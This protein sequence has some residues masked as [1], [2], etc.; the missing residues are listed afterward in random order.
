[1]R[2]PIIEDIAQK[3]AQGYD[4][5]ELPEDREKA[6]R[7]F[8]EQIGQRR[9]ELNSFEV[10]LRTGDII[11][12]DMTS[13]LNQTPTIDP[14]SREQAIA[15][16][17]D[18][19]KGVPWYRR[20]LA[21][22]AA[23]A[24]WWQENVSQ[25]SAAIAIA[26]AA[27]V[28]PGQNSFDTRLEKA[29]QRITAGKSIE[30]KSNRI[31]D[32]IEAAT[33]A[34][35][36]TDA[37]WGLKGAL[38][39]LVDPLNLVGLG[40]PGKAM[41]ALPLLRPLLFP[42]HVIDRTPDVVVRKIIGGGTTVAKQI[43]GL[44]QLT[45]PHFTTQVK[46]VERRVRA[47]VDGRFGPALLAD[48]V[49]KDTAE[50]LGNLSL[51]PEDGSPYSLR[52]VFNHIEQTFADSPNGLEKW[53][54]F[55]DDLQALTPADASASLS[56]FVS[57]LELKAITKG[58][59][60]LSGEVIEGTIRQR[61]AKTIG[62]LLE[63]LAIDETVAQGVAEAI[64]DKIF[65]L[66]D[67]IW[68]KKVEP[69]IIRPWAVS[70]LA[71]TGF[72]PMNMV[73]DI[74]VSTLGM[75][76]LGKRGWN[77]AEFKWLTAGLN[78][79]P[80]DLFNAE[81]QQRIL[82]D[83]GPNLYNNAV[84][85]P[86]VIK[87]IFKKAVLWPVTL[88][89][90]AGWAIRRSA[91]TNRYFKEFDG[92][93]RE[94]GADI[95]PEINAMRDFMQTEV[96]QGLE[97]LRDEISMKV[98]AAVS[99]GNP[100]VIR[101]LKKTMTS[102]TILRKSQMD[103][104]LKNP[105]VPTDVRRAFTDVLK[106]DVITA[107]NV[108]EV[109]A[110]VRTRL[111]DYH[112]FSAASIRD[113]FQDILRSIPQRPPRS[114]AEA[115]GMLRMFQQAFDDLTQLPR[116]INAHARLRAKGLSPTERSKILDEGFE[117]IDV[118]IGGARKELE[119]ILVK[120][121]PDI[122]RLIVEN[123]GT[124]LKKGAAI[125]AIDDIFGGYRGISEN[126]R[127]TW[128][129][130]RTQKE[131]LFAGT[132]REERG[133][134]FWNELE[135]IGIESWSAEYSSRAQA[136]TRIRD[137]WNQIFDMLPRDLTPKDRE[138]VRRGLD[139]SINAVD[140]DINKIR[141]SID[142]ATAALDANPTGPLADQKRQRIST[143]SDS[144]AV[145]KRQLNELVT[146]MEK[147]TKVRPR[148]ATPQA[149]RD[150]DRNLKLMQA[151]IPEAQS[152]DLFQH[153]SE[154]LDDIAE[155][156]A[157]RDEVFQSFIPAILKPEWESLKA[158]RLNLVRLAAEEPTTLGQQSIKRQQTQLTT[159]IK[160]FRDRIERGEAAQEV[161]N[162]TGI[163]R[164]SMTQ[165]AER[166]I[167]EGGAPT[168]IEEMIERVEALADA[169]DEAALSF[170]NNLEKGTTTFAE[171]DI[172]AAIETQPVIHPK[173]PLTKA[174]SETILERTLA[175]GGSITSLTGQD[176]K[177]LA[178]EGK[179]GRYLVGAFPDLEVRIPLSEASSDLIRQFTQEHVELL[180]KRNH[181][182]G[183]F[184]DEEA[185]VLDVSVSVEERNSAMRLSKLKNQDSIFDAVSGEVLPT[186]EIA[187]PFVA[188]RQQVY[189]E[190]Y[191]RVVQISEAPIL[192]PDKLDILLQA[193]T[194]DLLPTPILNEL[195]EE[196]LIEPITRLKNGKRRVK[197]TESGEDALQTRSPD[198]D[199]DGLTADMPPVVRELDTVVET[200][201]ATVE[202]M[203]DDMVRLWDNPPLRT[204]QESALG[205]S[206]DR[207]ADYMD[208]RP[209]LNDAIQVARQVGMK[210][211][212]TNYNRWFV[213][214][215]NRSTL[216][217][218][219]QRF[220]P[221]W[222]YES[223]RWP[224]LASL[225]AKRPVLAKSIMLSGGDWDYG[226]TP[227]PGGFEFNPMKGTAAGATR[228]TLARDFP[229][230]QSG[231]RGTIEQGFDW[232]ARGGVY[233]N[234]LVTSAVN[235]LQGEPAAIPPPPV[236]LI[237]HGMAAAGV[238]LPSG[239]RE[240]A[241]DSRYSQFLIDQVIADK[242]GANPVETR[243]LA[244]NGDEKAI[245]RLYLAEKEAALRM[246]AINQSSVLRYRPESKRD[247]IES[248]NEAIERIAGIPQDVMRDAQKL[249]I[250]YYEITA[251]SGPQHRAIREAS[252]NFDAFIGASIALRPLE[253]QRILRK[254]TAFWQ[255]IET[256]REEN[257][258]ARQTLS[259]R[260]KQG[261]VSGP[262]FLDERSALARERGAIFKAV[263]ALP[264]FIEV[265]IGLEA[266]LAHIKKYG[267]PSPLVSPI[268]EALEQYYSISAE[269]SMDPRT[270]DIDWGEYF[271]KREDVLNQ[272][273]EPIRSIMQSE[274]RRAETESERLLEV[275][276]PLM[277]EYF[278]IRSGVMDEIEQV[279]P[280][281][282]EAYAEYR[283]LMNFVQRA[284]TP[285][286]KQF[287]TNQARSI[288]S[289]NPQLSMAEAII[290]QTRRRMRAENPDMER[291]YQLFIARP[292]SIPPPGVPQRRRGRTGSFGSFG[293][294]GAFGSR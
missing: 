59:R 40:I 139:S 156:Q 192:S 22:A 45:T 92:A 213:N 17:E 103:I 150:I 197:V 198:R 60:K 172:V 11:G 282:A 26:G 169:G 84:D 137:G 222:M 210:R 12:E 6:K 181:Y 55:H 91:L 143:L 158:Q 244:E 251:I 178:A 100:Q 269:D 227:V 186:E 142:D 53:T 107:D 77:D 232:F 207:I 286:E 188:G 201:M 127:N 129:N 114:A 288:L 105:D 37:V 43:P 16:V 70:A 235:L 81:V 71:F 279:N 247:F 294:F 218:V 177:V 250:T 266:R 209:V 236:S 277:R 14:I 39:L 52:N 230:L 54:K 83:T 202:G 87:K 151:S 121:R 280:I 51:F 9:S 179:I 208:Q 56:G 25:P 126:L 120:A 268:D 220:V 29:R 123:A 5:L 101:D 170:R 203:A 106:D 167:D 157:H 195:I 98:W 34:Y 240:L 211:A 183:T 212:V 67:N 175:E 38:E 47:T 41:K 159:K 3:F 119:E 153:T 275:A 99:T 261:F 166:L 118:E 113:T 273:D 239:L 96:P 292:G 73:E 7:L 68:L 131:A 93:L 216:D 284:S 283:R 229:E 241:F 165:T 245:S 246:I 272:Y 162:V 242:F 174:N 72:F 243:H 94:A 194:N 226:Y 110:K 205:S 219:M 8:A 146:K 173:R 74:A 64:D 238:S 171:P 196:G 44:K 228:R 112:K 187:T 102:S 20:G 109:M 163:T 237:L 133:N 287:L 78:D 115:T 234:P 57:S 249:G 79:V 285:Q 42:I 30:D 28:I 124:P 48:G 19:K 180:R 214:Y 32:Y 88:S 264:E 176:A 144:L 217:Y 136:A 221:F 254:I 263:S 117:T 104:L 260:F 154:I 149:L 62:S 80:I 36:E 262:D 90:K 35:R 270:G 27:K 206:F 161:E 223:R 82:L 23:G 224:R 258:E 75:G 65:L 233:F 135:D 253:E 31:R 132:P 164:R 189:E 257:L 141:M 76:G 108:E 276:S 49:A 111:F 215:D 267:K 66:W 145:N 293:S 200:Q 18:A 125:Q 4:V 199:I 10:L 122:E 148:N 138:L 21:K 2:D 256:Q 63:K 130:Y 259:D 97:H 182:V 168:T 33:E 290:R 86:G 89:S 69:M 160:R 225:A 271:D 58:G 281:V 191:S 231:Y 185:L 193:K 140:A 248:T 1:M 61:R 95:I 274:I 255:A 46:E 128:T 265:P 15:Q 85:E 13:F 152:H 289:T 147:F 155:L 50:K 204:D 116:E 278:G 134:W 24:E 252:T 190:L 291:V 184:V